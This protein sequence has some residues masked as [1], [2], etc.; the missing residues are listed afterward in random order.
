MLQGR[1]SL[2]AC[3]RLSFAYNHSGHEQSPGVRAHFCGLLW[4]VMNV[5][6]TPSSAR[7]PSNVA[8]SV[9][10]KVDQR[11][12]VLEIIED[13]KVLAP[14]D[15]LSWLS[16]QDGPFIRWRFSQESPIGFCLSRLG[17]RVVAP[18]YADPSED[19]ALLP[20]KEFPV[21]YRLGQLQPG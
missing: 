21:G 13:D 7:R 1:D 19:H 10:V 4:G 12:L 3:H 11:L 14:P 8:S 16:A 17:T 5:A 15:R 20:L 9:S 2:S 6:G 18:A